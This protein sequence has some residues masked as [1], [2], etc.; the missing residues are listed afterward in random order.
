MCAEPA[1]CPPSVWFESFARMTQLV[2]GRW[3]P[4]PRL[5]LCTP[6]FHISPAPA[7]L[8]PSQAAWRSLHFRGHSGC[9]SNYNKAAKPFRYTF[10]EE[11]NVLISRKAMAVLCARPRRSGG[12]R[13]DG[14]SHKCSRPIC[15]RGWAAIQ[16]V[17]LQLALLPHALHRGAVG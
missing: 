16:K 17:L 8:M 1:H 10:E 2:S 11:G 7:S 12:R 6:S 4:G 13:E 15:A 9:E 3:A 5:P 14:K